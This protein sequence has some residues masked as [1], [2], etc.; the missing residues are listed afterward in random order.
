MVCAQRRP[1]MQALWCMYKGVAEYAQHRDGR[2][3]KAS[4]RVYLC[5][6]RELAQAV[7]CAVALEWWPPRPLAVPIIRWQPVFVRRYPTGH[8]S[9]GLSADDRMVMQSE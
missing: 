1:C 8:L 6:Y 5:R 7:A 4:T 3:I 2:I 9:A